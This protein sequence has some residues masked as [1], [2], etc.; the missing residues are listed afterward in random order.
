MGHRVGHFGGGR[1]ES[2]GKLH[3]RK[4]CRRPITP[5]PL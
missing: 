2:F 5:R 1:L 4:I 3:H